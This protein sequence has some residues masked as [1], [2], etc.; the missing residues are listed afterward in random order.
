MPYLIDPQFANLGHMVRV[1][2][3]VPVLLDAL[4]EYRIRDAHFSAD[5]PV[6]RI[7]GIGDIVVSPTPGAIS[8][9]Y[10]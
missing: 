4:P 9:Q 1:V 2:D 5:S 7:V 6:E 3:I 8:A 10:I